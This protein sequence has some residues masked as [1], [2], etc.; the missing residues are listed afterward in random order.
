MSAI[1]LTFLIIFTSCFGNVLLA[2]SDS[3]F[4]LTPAQREVYIQKA[5]ALRAT[6]DYAGTIKMLDTI[7]MVN[8]LD[9]P[10]LLYKGDVLL[11]SKKF[12]VHY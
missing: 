6:E 1:A 4:T 2:Q 12:K 8:P 9:A 7:L 5:N 11:Q 3:L 10:M